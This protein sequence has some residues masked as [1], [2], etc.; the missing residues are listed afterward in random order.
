MPSLISALNGTTLVASLTF[1]ITV[2]TASVVIYRRFFHPL[3]KVP[4]PFLSS[5][6]TLYQSYYNRRY[7]L[8]IDELHKKYGM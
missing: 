8:K 5:V 1:L 7:Y 4:G 6:S 2:Y 3:A